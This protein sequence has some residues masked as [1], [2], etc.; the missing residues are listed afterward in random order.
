MS[1][2][3]IFDIVNTYIKKNYKTVIDSFCRF[4]ERSFPLFLTQKEG[5]SLD[6]SCENP[7]TFASLNQKCLF[8]VIGTNN[9]KNANYYI[10]IY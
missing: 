4:V 7:I 5:C 10:I 3:I 1:A 2:I 6:I 8:F 9:N